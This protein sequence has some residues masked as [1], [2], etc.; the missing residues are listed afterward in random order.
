MTADRPNGPPRPDCLAGFPHPADRDR[1]IGHEAA[2]RLLAAAV[3]AGRLHHAWLISGPPGIGKA[4]LAYRFA[5]FM[6]AR[7][8]EG[9]GDAN[10]HG[11]GPA[12]A[13]LAVAPDHRVFRQIAA[14][15]HGNLFQLR[16]QLNDKARPA[17]YF[18]VIRIDEVRAMAP[19]LA[20]TAHQPGWRAVVV[21]SADEM[22]VNAQNALLKSLEE[23]P[24]R[25]VFLLVA[26]APG[27]LPATI[28]SRC[29]LLAL[30]PLDETAQNDVIA[31][32]CPEI[33][34]E[35]RLLLARL[36]E[37]S[38]GRAL[39]LAGQ[40][41]LAVYRDVTGLIAGMPAL[42]VVK[43]HGLG[44]RLGRKTA[45][46]EYHAMTRLIDWWLARL[47]RAKATGEAPPEI[48]AGEA[49]VN[50]RLAAASSLEHWI[51]V[52]E[53]VGRLVERADA[54][55]LDR[56]AVTLAVFT[57]IERTVRG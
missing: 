36:G 26:H 25:T 33:P 34:P 48:V 47:I 19:F 45:E 51:E 24:P 54:V 12:A 39:A 57:M 2:E 14:G 32:L 38:P 23:P 11:G 22:N 17:A 50:Q 42:D 43:L 27:R 37:G 49:A 1:L 21:D 9:N 56:K 31:E 53:K 10:G 52:W 35:E 41:G 4:T 28:R 7:D 6:L 13:G 15:G 20:H 30:R 44:D 55:N 16:R 46:P 40:H 29:R 18:T 3:A 8:G 5:R